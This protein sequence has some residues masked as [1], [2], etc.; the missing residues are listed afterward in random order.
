M[1][2]D[3]FRFSILYTKLLQNRRNPLKKVGE[4]ADHKRKAY[5]KNS[6]KEVD[7]RKT[8]KALSST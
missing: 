1:S 7:G 3:S 4:S 8:A 2:I 6:D 5:S